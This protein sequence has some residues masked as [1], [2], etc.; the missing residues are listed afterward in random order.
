MAPAPGLACVGGD[1]P[2]GGEAPVAGA[3]RCRARRPP[4]PPSARKAGRRVD[5]DGRASLQRRRRCARDPVPRRRHPR[6]RSHRRSRRLSRRPRGQCGGRGRDD[7]GAAALD[8]SERAEVLAAVRDAVPFQ[9][10]S[11]DRRNGAASG[12]QAAA[13]TQA[14]APEVPTPCL[15]CRLR[16]APMSAR[17]TRPSLVP[18]AIFTSPPSRR[19]LSR[20]DVARD[21]GRRLQGFQRRPGS[22]ARDAM[23]GKGR[24][25]SDPRAS[26]RLPAPW[27][28]PGRSWPSQTPSRSAVRPPLPVTRARSE[29]S[30]GPIAAG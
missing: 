8:A 23:F 10:R 22:D 25:F 26:C 24:S 11:C 19:R 18:R 14:P 9:R 30:P 2:R 5:A 13:F 7:R 28:A 29:P 3:T 27:V 15:Y 1:G 17:I 20:P 12:R 4:R 6:R 21:S 16:A